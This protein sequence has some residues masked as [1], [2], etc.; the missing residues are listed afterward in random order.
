LFEFETSRCIRWIVEGVDLPA[1]LD[2]GD[3]GV[4]DTAEE[5]IDSSDF[6][7]SGTVISD[8]EGNCCCVWC[9]GPEFACPLKYP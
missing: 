8:V 1:L 5:I 9:V 3:I 4:L 6:E 7:R 2:A